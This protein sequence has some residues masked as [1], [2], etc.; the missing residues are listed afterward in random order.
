MP[1]TSP[2]EVYTP[3]APR[4]TMADEE[5]PDAATLAYELIEEVARR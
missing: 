4:T 5:H 3:L 2:P 1:R